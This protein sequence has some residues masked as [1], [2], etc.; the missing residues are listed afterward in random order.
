MDHRCHSNWQETMS[1]TPT[2]GRVVVGS[3]ASQKT[4]DDVGEVPTAWHEDQRATVGTVGRL[5]AVKT[6]TCSR[7]NLRTKSYRPIVPTTIVVC[8]CQVGGT[9]DHSGESS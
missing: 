7:Q 9:Q 3:G 5:G 2:A 4:E 8:Q 6:A 1:A